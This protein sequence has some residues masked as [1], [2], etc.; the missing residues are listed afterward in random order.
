MLKFSSN[1]GRHTYHRGGQTFQFRTSE[2]HDN[3]E[4]L[5]QGRFKENADRRRL[6]NALPKFDSFEAAKIYFD[7]EKT[8]VKA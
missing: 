6:L 3:S 1:G 2:V 7:R 8:H 5:A 4:F